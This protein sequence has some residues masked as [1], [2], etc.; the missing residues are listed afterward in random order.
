VQAALDARLVAARIRIVP[1]TFEETF[2]TL[3]TTRQENP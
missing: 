1:A 2:V 3:A